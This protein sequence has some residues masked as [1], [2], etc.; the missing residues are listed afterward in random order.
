VVLFHNDDDEA[1]E[2]FEALAELASDFRKRKVYKVLIG[3][4][5]MK[6]NAVV[7]SFK[8]YT[9][10]SIYLISKSKTGEMHF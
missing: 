5:N 1:D 2:I 10:P 4:I 8:I 6:K 3:K 9:Y 7:D